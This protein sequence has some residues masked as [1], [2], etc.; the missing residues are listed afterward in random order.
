MSSLWTSLTSSLWDQSDVLP[1]GPVRHPAYRTLILHCTIRRSLGIAYL[2][3]SPGNPP[4]CLAYRGL[5]AVTVD[6]GLAPWPPP[7]FRRPRQMR[8]QHRA[9]LVE[10][11]VLEPMVWETINDLNEEAGERMAPCTELYLSTAVSQALLLDVELWR[12]PINHGPSCLITAT[13]TG[14]RAIF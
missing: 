8:A 13:P 5:Q 4:P 11:K 3:R 6:P 2:I 1:P 7:R 10:D 12:L 9:W 14:G